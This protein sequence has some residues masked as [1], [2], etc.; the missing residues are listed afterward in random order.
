[1]PFQSKKQ[2]AFM[3]SQHPDIAAKWQE[4]YGQPKKLPM[5]KHGAKSVLGKKSNELPS[6]WTAMK[7]KKEEK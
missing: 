5:Y 7:T 3:Y 6:P 1:M 4:E 2:E